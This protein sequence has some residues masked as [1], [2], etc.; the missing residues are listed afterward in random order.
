MIS[1]DLLILSH[2]LVLCQLLLLESHGNIPYWSILICLF[3]QVAWWIS[4]Q[5]LD[6]QNSPLNTVVRSKPTDISNHIKIEFLKMSFLRSCAFVLFAGC[7][8]LNVNIFPRQSLQQKRVRMDEM[9]YCTVL[10]AWD[11]AGNWQ[12]ALQ[13]LEEMTSYSTLICFK[14]VGAVWCGRSGNGGGGGGSNDLFLGMYAPC[15]LFGR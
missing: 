3:H 8:F 9:A 1:Y 6:C 4:K 14:S 7:C 5:N 13:Q 12:Q 2:Y 11:R 15:C 10:S